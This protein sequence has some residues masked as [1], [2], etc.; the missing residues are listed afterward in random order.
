M[1]YRSRTFSPKQLQM[2]EELVLFAMIARYSEVMEYTST[3]NQECFAHPLHKDVFRGIQLCIQQGQAVEPVNVLDRMETPDATYWLNQLTDSV[4]IA[5]N[6]EVKT[7]VQDLHEISA[8]RRL[9]QYLKEESETRKPTSQRLVELS[10]MLREM[11]QSK[12]DTPDDAESII[13]QVFID[14][15]TDKTEQA[16]ATPWKQI[17]HVCSGGFR[18]GE[19]IVIAGR[20]GMGKSA[21]ALTL[22]KHFAE[23][24][25]K[26]AYI[27]LEMSKK[28]LGQ[29]LLSQLSGIPLELLRKQELN[30][31]HI[32]QAQRAV[33]WDNPLEVIDNI[34]NIADVRT[35]LQRQQLHQQPVKA[36]IIDYLQLMQGNDKKAESRQL[37]VS[38]MSREL[39]LMSQEFQLPVVILCQLNRSL[40]QRKDKRPFLSDIRE[41]GAIE[42]DADLV[43]FLYRDSV[44]NE[45]SNPTQLEFIL[46]KHRHGPTYNAMLHFEANTCTVKDFT[47]NSFF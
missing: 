11:E 13:Q 29:R 32:Y 15:Q 17:N 23:Q 26:T 24:G 46:A 33:Q 36:I 44:Y 22:A 43:F 40:E 14:I 47:A 10:D 42:Q 27:S 34:R 25:Q 12:P 16:I 45:E 5:T 38:R 39:K 41:S 8:A 9:Q 2:R 18:A 3:L 37:E 4:S 1:T 6:M 20:P 30:S 35:Y 21:I 19:L 7:W 28:Q 31:K